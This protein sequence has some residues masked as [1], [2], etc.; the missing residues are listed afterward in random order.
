MEL[1]EP[2]VV[3]PAVEA[4]RLLLADM[5]A[6]WEPVTWD[7]P[8]PCD[9]WTVRDVVAHVTSMATATKPH[10]LWVYLRAGADLDKASGSL[11]A[12]VLGGRSDDDVIEL[13]RSSAAARHTS[14]GLRAVGVLAELVT[15]LQ[16]LAVAT[17]RPVDL[18]GDHLVATLIYLQRRAKGNTRFHLSAHGRVSVLDGAARTAGLSLRATDVDWTHDGGAGDGRNRERAVTPRGSVEGPAASLIL[19]MAGRLVPPEAVTGRLTGDG[20]AHLLARPPH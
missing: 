18:P 14:P 20:V 19:A 1:L 9:G 10:A 5:A 15:H 7:A 12:E 17:C 11:A 3:W 6:R 16:D 4:D 2:D 8:T 13:L